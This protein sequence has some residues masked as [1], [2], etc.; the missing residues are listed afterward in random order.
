MTMT[1][2]VMESAAP[3]G[4]LRPGQRLVGIGELGV[5]A[6]DKAVARHQFERPE[7]TQVVDAAPAHGQQELHPL[8]REGI[9]HLSLPFGRFEAANL[10][11]GDGTRNPVA[12]FYRCGP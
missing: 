5:L 7:H 3:S 12:A 8:F 2:S 9:V 11:F 10:A 4:Q 6:F 1:I